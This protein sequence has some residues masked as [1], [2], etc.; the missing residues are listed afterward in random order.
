[1][2]VATLK[3]KIVWKVNEY[4]RKLELGKK[5]KQI[6]QKVN[7]PKACL[8]KENMEAMELYENHGLW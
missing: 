2:D 3:N 5:I 1:M 6:V 7:V 4:Q 8:D